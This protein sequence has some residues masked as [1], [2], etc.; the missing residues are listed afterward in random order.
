MGKLNEESIAD[1]E[2]EGQKQKLIVVVIENEITNITIFNEVEGTM[3]LNNVIR[4]RFNF[5]IPLL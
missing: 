3:E 5:E 2:S 4:G 1:N